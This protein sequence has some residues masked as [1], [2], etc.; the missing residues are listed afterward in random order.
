MLVDNNLSV[1]RQINRRS[2]KC[3]AIKG[4]VFWGQCRVNHSL[5]QSVARPLRTHANNIADLPGAND[6][7]T[8]KGQCWLLRA[9]I[10][11]VRCSSFVLYGHIFPS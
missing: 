9:L 11:S 8:P 3:L 5:V 2:P 6:K 4:E 10:S 1:A 7:R